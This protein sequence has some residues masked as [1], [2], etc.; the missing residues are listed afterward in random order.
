M[1]ELSGGERYLEIKELIK[2]LEAEKKEIAKTLTVGDRVSYNGDLYEWISY[3]NSS[4]AWKPLY[5]KAYSLLDDEGQ[6]I[7]GEAVVDAKK[8]R[9]DH[10]FEKK[11]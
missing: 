6:V 2:A 4:T 11:S 8:P 7:M 1:T 10:K 9:I 5:E 3:E